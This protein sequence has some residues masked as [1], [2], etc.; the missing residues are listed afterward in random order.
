M[1]QFFQKEY[2][3][4]QGEW[5]V[6]TIPTHLDGFRLDKLLKEEWSLSKQLIKMLIREDDIK[7][8]DRR[9][10][11]Q[12]TVAKGDIVSMRL[13]IKE[14]ND[15]P[16]N[17][18][19]KNFQICYEDDFILVVNKG[20]GL[21]VHPN[22]P[23]EKETLANGIAA[24]YEQTKQKHK[25]RHIHRL[26][27]DTTG[28]VL[29]AKDPLTQSLLDEQLRLKMIHRYYYALV[30][31]KVRNKKGLIDKPIGKDRHHPNRRVISQRGKEA[32]TEYKVIEMY[33]HASLV[34]VCLQTGRTHQIRVHFQS[35]GH[36][37]IGDL[38]YGK[39]SNIRF[40]RQA[41][42]AKI[43]TFTH[44]YTYKKITVETEFPDDFLHLKE[45]I[46]QPF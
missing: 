3:Q 9:G 27:R 11:I 28:L 6:I 29:F 41:L 19:I 8:N 30:H 12:Q 31:G 1:R 14:S 45:K 43:V 10:T 42:H 7:I 26:D 5:L 16:L 15:V 33:S 22:I 17:Q 37:L 21:S 24:Y 2:M 4:I 46:K 32:L 39:K 34:K 18:Q 20:A 44:P 40:S 36:P 13:L 23:T 38:L 35:V 25:V